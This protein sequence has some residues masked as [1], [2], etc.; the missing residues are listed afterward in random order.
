MDKVKEPKIDYVLPIDPPLK[1]GGDE[2]IEEILK[3]NEEA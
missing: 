1:E 3:R 2:S